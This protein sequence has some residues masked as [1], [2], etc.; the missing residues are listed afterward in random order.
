MEAC[1]PTKRRALAPLD[2]NALGT[3][4]NLFKPSTPGRSPVKMAIEGR[5]RLLEMEG[6]ESPAGK[7]AC[8][9]RDEDASETSTSPDVSSVFDT[10]GNDASWATATSES[11]AVAMAA[12]TLGLGT[13]SPERRVASSPRRGTLTRQQIREKAEIL[14][15]RLSLANYKVRT[16]QT[17]VPLADLQRRPIPRDSTPR[18]VR[19]Q[20]PQSSPP[21]LPSDHDDDDNT[22]NEDN[23]AEMK[24]RSSTD[25]QR[26]EI[27]EQLE[28]DEP[29]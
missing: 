3:P 25:S 19:V 4:K 9:G 29:R 1:S 21:P 20:S 27:M 16:G 13:A 22:N 28:D 14:R 7:K 17:T 24:R 15:L 6:A 10:S 26:T 8:L 23:H 18:V 5:K 12:A 11:D 2:A